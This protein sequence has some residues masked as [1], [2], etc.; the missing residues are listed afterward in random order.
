MNP[1]YIVLAVMFLGGFLQWHT[2]GAEAERTQENDSIVSKE[3]LE[4]LKVYW[5]RLKRKVSIPFDG[6]TPSEAV[7]RLNSLLKLNIVVHADVLDHPLIKQEF[8]DRM[9]EEVLNDICR[10]AQAQWTIAPDNGV[11]CIQIGSK[12]KIEKLEKQYAALARYQSELR[13]SFGSSGSS[14]DTIRKSDHPEDKK[15]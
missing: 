10:R 4:V 13:R 14:W 7:S 15:P 5:E 1:T 8:R 2:G 9:A 3:Q 6:D 12:R 11:L